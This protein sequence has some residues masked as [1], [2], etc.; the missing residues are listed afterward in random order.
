MNNESTCPHCNKTFSYLSVE[1]T[2]E[3]PFCGQIVEVPINAEVVDSN[4]EPLATTEAG[5]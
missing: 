3:C 2:L 4:L 5:V 1:S